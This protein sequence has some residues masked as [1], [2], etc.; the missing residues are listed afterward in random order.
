MTNHLP[1]GRNER[2]NRQPQPTE[3]D[4]DRQ[5]EALEAIHREVEHRTEDAVATARL[6]LLACGTWTPQQ[7]AILTE[8]AETIATALVVSRLEWLADWQCH[9]ASDDCCLSLECATRLFGV[10]DE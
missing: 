7:D 9:A 2:E 3:A 1:T 4:R 10:T 5:A 8:L 6:Q